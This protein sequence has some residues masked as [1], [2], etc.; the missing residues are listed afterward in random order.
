MKLKLPL[1]NFLCFIALSTAA[2]EKA[3]TNTSKSAYAKLRAV[4]MDDV[5]WTKGFW[6]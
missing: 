6:A 1:I 3:L 4:D 2:Q 5:Q